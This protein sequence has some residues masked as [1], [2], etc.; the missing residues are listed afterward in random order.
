MTH[1]QKNT[2]Q[3]VIF[4]LVLMV[5]GLIGTLW[6]QGNSEPEPG[7]SEE[8]IERFGTDDC[9]ANYQQDDGSAWPDWVR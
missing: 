6:F 2:F 8:Y 1:E 7:C 5:I 9:E 4:V 3:A